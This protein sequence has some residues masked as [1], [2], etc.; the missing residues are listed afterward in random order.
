MNGTPTSQGEYNMRL[1]LGLIALVMSIGMC[2]LIAGELLNL[3]A[4]GHFTGAG[5]GAGFYM[6]PGVLIHSDMPAAA[7]PA[8]SRPVM[9]TAVFWILASILIAGVATA[10]Y[11]FSGFFARS[12]LGR[13]KAPDGAMYASRR[14]I[15][16]LV[17]DGPQDGR[18]VLGRVGGRLVAAEVR[19]S[20]AVIG[21]TQTGK[22]TSL[23][24]PCIVEH[25]GP[26]LATSVKTDIL[27]DTIAVRRQ[28]GE[29]FVFDPA[30][31][32]NLHKTHGWT[33]LARCKQ[34]EGAQ[35]TAK[36]LTQ[37]AK[38]AIGGA[39]E[40]GF[41]YDQA[42][43]L[44]APLLYAAAL[45]DLGIEKVLE[46]LDTKEEDEP[47]REFN[48]RDDGMGNAPANTISA[49]LGMAAE[50]RDSVYLTARGVLEAYRTPSVL[51]S[52][53]RS[54]IKPMSLLDG[55]SNTAYLCAP[56][57]EQRQLAPLYATLIKEMVDAAYE[58]YTRT[59]QKLDPPLMIVLDEA[60][61]IAPIPELNEIASTAAGVGIQLVTVFQDLGQVRER[62]GHDKAQ[63]IIS[64]HRATVVLSGIKCEHTLRW[65][66]EVTGEQEVSQVSFTDGH[67]N[68]SSTQSTT[69]RRLLP[70][71]VLREMKTD[72][73]LLIYGNLKPAR[74]DLR[75]WYKERSLKALIN[76]AKAN[77]PARLDLVTGEIIDARKAIERHYIAPPSFDQQENLG[78]VSVLP[79]ALRSRKSSGAT[80][81]IDPTPPADDDENEADS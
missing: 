30:Q 25:R 56:I 64:N 4:T 59:G 26:V 68:K 71:N 52:S 6:A 49:V 44:L 63:T 48:N 45:G 8:G 67:A 32:N 18:V 42:Q 72:T 47:C 35:K 61:N 75:P 62:W 54:E 3:L 53:R 76:N 51:D 70:S 9:S 55:N 57:S 5:I 69:Y 80:A 10:L 19:Q 39:N 15:E 73:G 21:P 11:R 31:V 22:T 29:V 2:F 50:Q 7:W 20:T 23:V 34:F 43:T 17:V 40:N 24:V 12:L 36:A 33:P 66:A 58:M 46:W 27:D 14:D 74:I 28:M 16:R 41:W 38:Q 60:A 81:T 37:T 78:R 65:V 13:G 77:D 1:I 79:A